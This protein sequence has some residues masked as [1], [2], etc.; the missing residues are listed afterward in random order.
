MISDQESI[1]AEIK[2]DT[3]KIRENTEKMRGLYET[4]IPQIKE[5]VTQNLQFS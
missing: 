5:I 2:E 4:M 3:I 1:N